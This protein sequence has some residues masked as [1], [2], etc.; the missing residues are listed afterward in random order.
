MDINNDGSINDSDRAIL[1]NIVYNGAIYDDETMERA[2]LNRDR[3]IDEEDLRL[4]NTYILN[5]KLSL[6]IKHNK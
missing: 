4:L 6:K 5:G 1:N 2:D 3:N